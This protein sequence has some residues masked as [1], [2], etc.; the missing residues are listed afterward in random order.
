MNIRL[1]KDQKIRINR[2]SDLYPVMQA[3]LLRESKTDR[4][5]EH[6]W[7]VSLDNANR[8][9]NIELVSMGSVLGTI[10]EPMEIFSISLQK[11][12]VRVI[13]VHNHPSGNTLP[14]AAD[15]DLTDRLIQCGRIL[16][17]P[18]ADHLIITEE[19]YLSFANTGLMDELE[20]SEKYVPGYILAQR[21]EKAGSEKGKHER[22]KEIA[23][24][25]KRQG[26]EPETI[27]KVTGLSTASIK[28]LKT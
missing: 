5:R 2:P 8:V 12:A 17:V 26:M 20:R 15:K 6:F 16:G 22:S 9:L 7:T 3:I 23:R 19:N 1:K 21:Y 13:L 4:N 11:R 27:A 10:A 18:V 24:E 14:S 25:L 28:K